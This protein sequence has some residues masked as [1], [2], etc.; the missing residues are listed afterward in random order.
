MSDFD[1]IVHDMA[2]F[3]SNEGLKPLAMKYLELT[4]PKQSNVAMLKDRVF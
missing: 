3:M 1:L 2:E 4:N